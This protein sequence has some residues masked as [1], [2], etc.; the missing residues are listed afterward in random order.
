MNDRQVIASPYIDW[1]DAGGPPLFFL[2]MMIWGATETR[3]S[4]SYFMKDY[5]IG[6]ACTKSLTLKSL[7]R[8]SMAGQCQW[9]KAVVISCVFIFLARMLAVA[10]QLCWSLLWTRGLFKKSWASEDFLSPVLTGP[11]T[12]FKHLQ[13]AFF[14]QHAWCIAVNLRSLK[15]WSHS[16][17]QKLWTQLLIEHP[18]EVL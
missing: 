4:L 1:L 14:C 12:Q 13:R 5:R 15:L 8:P 6:R 7:I 10:F 11:L 16:S 2:Q 17:R 3:V 18:P 9:N